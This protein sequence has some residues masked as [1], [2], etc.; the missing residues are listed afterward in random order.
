MK[1]PSTHLWALIRSLTPAEKRY[2]KTHFAPKEGQLTLLFDTLNAQTAYDSI[3]L[4]NVLQVPPTQ[5]KVLK[6][7]LQELLTKSLVAGNNKRSLRSGIR[8][9]LEEV[10]L[11]LERELFTEAV[12]KLRQLEKTCRQ[13]GLTLYLYEIL[14]KLHE[15]EHLELD[16]SSSESLTHYEQLLFLQATLRQQQALSEIQQQLD[17][18]NSF[19]SGRRKTLQRMLDRLYAMRA[20]YMDVHSL[21]AWIQHTASCLALMGEAQA[22]ITWRNY[23]LEVFQQNPPLQDQLPLRYLQILKQLADPAGSLPSINRVNEITALAR[24]VI[25][26]H[27]QY[28]P[29]FIYFLWARLHVHYLHNEW[30]TIIR[31]IAPAINRHLE[32]Y[33]LSNYETAQ[34]MYAL[35]MATCLIHQQP[36]DA[37]HYS[38]AYIANNASHDLALKCCIHILQLIHAIENPAITDPDPL[39]RAL[40]RPAATKLDHFSPLY[41]YHLSLFQKIKSRPLD[42]PT[43]AAEALLGIADYPFDPI[44]PYYSLLHIEKWLQAKAAKRKWKET[45]PERR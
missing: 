9:G 15:T 6:H 10:D 13:F 22:A 4:L 21:L 27:P 26:Q 23:L 33:Q 2:F 41:H 31:H 24:K 28:S 44:L 45:I 7:Q 39:L 36:A 35:L 12:R 18:W 8:L 40:K 25:A 29:H 32:Q 37:Q 17:N 43:L 42:L 19:F 20:E 1:P 16:F 30:E 11:L 34:K 38:L 14:E 3:A 5:Y